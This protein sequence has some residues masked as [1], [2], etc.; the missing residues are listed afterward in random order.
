MVYCETLRAP[1]KEKISQPKHT[2]KSKPLLYNT[3]KGFPVSGTM[4]Y[5]KKKSGKAIEKKQKPTEKSKHKNKKD[6]GLR[7][8]MS[9]QSAADGTSSNSKPA[10]E[11][12]DHSLFVTYLK[13]TSASKQDLVATNQ[14]AKLLEK[15]RDMISEER[16]NTVSNFFRAGGRKSGLASLYSQKISSK[17]TAN[18]KGWAGYTTPATIMKFHEVQGEETKG[19]TRKS[20]GG[21]RKPYFGFMGRAIVKASTFEFRPFLLNIVWEGVVGWMSVHVLPPPAAFRLQ[22][23]G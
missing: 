2:I 1:Q 19:G 20:K 16:K 12:E 23:C 13:C 15:Y 21:A 5:S 3:Q 9:S 10:M 7:K 18:E 8:Y 4:A 17:S 14:A 6:P 22:Q 11:K